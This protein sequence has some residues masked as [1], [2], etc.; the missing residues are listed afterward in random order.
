MLSYKALRKVEET[1]EEPIEETASLENEMESGDDC[2]SIEEIGGTD[3]QSTSIAAGNDFSDS[4]KKPHLFDHIKQLLV[5]KGGFQ[6]FL[7]PITET[8]EVWTPSEHF[9][10]ISASGKRSRYFKTNV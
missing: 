4:P 3:V 2:S 7:R 6:R 1:E 9:K 10:K 8:D 5:Q